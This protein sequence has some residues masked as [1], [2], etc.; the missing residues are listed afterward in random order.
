MANVYTSLADLVKINDMNLADLDVSDLL[1]DAPLL[2]ALAADVAS[3][4]TEHKYLKETGAPVVGF[5]AANNGRENKASADT[6]V[7]ITLQILDAS[8]AVDKALADGYR[9][10]AAAYLAREGKRHLKAAFAAAELQLVN[11]VSA[12]A[13]GFVG[14]LAAATIDAV[15]DAM[16]VN[17]GGDTED[18]CT[19][20][21][22]LRTSDDGN[23]VTV[24]TGNDGEMVMGDSVVIRKEGSSTGFHPAYFTPISGWMG[25][26][27]GSAYSIGRIANIDFDHTLDDDM[28][29]DLLSK[30]PAGR[31]PNLLVMNR[32]ASKQLQQSRTATNATG[33]PAPFPVE[34]FN[35]PIVTT[36]AI[37]NTIDVVA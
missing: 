21:L 1:Q 5:R 24:I 19:T 27:I 10:G 37:L 23:D 31:E 7:T 18:A 22:A 3:N 14:M 29:S 34:A 13:A 8:F 36:E 16:V 25:L 28:I 9:K 35:V 6:L 4:G 20:V 11:G 2:A 12:D 30:F 32:T 33:A 26:Q 17:A 15:A